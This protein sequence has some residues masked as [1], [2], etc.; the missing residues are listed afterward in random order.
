MEN[1]LDILPVGIFIL[2]SEFK[3]AH[4]NSSLENFFGLQ[5]EE[6]LGRDKSQLIRERIHTIFEKGDEFKNRVL[7]TYADNT[8][9]EHFICHVLPAEGRRERWLE[10][11]SQ[12]I[13]KGPYQGGRVEIYI[14]V[15]ER[16]LAEEEVNWINAQALQ[17]QENEKARIASN[18]HDELGQSLLALK[19]SLENLLVSVENRARPG[20]I[21][22]EITKSVQRIEE[23][24]REVSTISS[25]LMPSLLE[26][27]GLEETLIWMKDNYASL[28]G[29]DIK[30]QS[31]GLSGKRLSQ[32]KEVAIFR[33]FQEGLINIVKHA[34]ARHIDL[35]LIYSYPKIIATITDDGK[36]FDTENRNTGTGLRI[37][38]RRVS[39]LNGTVK[40]SSTANRGSVIRVEIPDYPEEVKDERNR[41]R[42]GG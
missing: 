9:V 13:I 22:A 26:P 12:P 18:L 29:L 32:A 3:I 5:R 35:K 19:F 38:K 31:H 37:M 36:G 20:H 17:I 6:V 10:H 28:Y 34:D 16:M 2:D 21:K 15:T 42:L 23:L 40:I 25:H 30:F 33:V 7:A 41:R 4:I 8:Y 24:S 11:S 39:E 14:D 1:I 27:L